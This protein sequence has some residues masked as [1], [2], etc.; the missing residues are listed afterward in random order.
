MDGHP[1]VGP[2]QVAPNLPAP[3]N[4]MVCG[5]PEAAHGTDGLAARVTAAQAV[6]DDFQRST[7]KYGA[8]VPAADWLQWSLQLAQQLQQVLGTIGE[9]PSVSARPGPL[10]LLGAEAILRQA[11]T[12]AIE[13][14]DSR[15]DA[16]CILCELDPRGLC[17]DHESDLEQADAYL[18]LARELGIEVARNE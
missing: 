13:F 16:E 5:Q 8:G 17:P 18:S 11:L 12:D 3:D 15:L 1:F 14:R 10:E 6:L 4:C 9:P 7:G 2:G